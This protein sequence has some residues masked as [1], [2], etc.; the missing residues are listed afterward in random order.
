MLPEEDKESVEGSSDGSPTSLEKD[1]Q[2]FDS[3][4]ND[5]LLFDSALAVQSD[6][7]ASPLKLGPAVS[8]HSD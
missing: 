8:C 3:A 4:G 1:A 7:Q 6:S 2:T 5:K